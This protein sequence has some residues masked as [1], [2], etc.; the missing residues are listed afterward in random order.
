MLTP[1][2]CEDLNR[3][4]TVAS[5]E[6]GVGAFRGWGVHHQSWMQVQQQ[7]TLLSVLLA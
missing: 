5:A 3:V 4:C 6:S 2:R 7:Y 1:L